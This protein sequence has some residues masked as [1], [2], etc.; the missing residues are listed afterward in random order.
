MGG[1][2]R[3][4]KWFI[5]LNVFLNTHRSTGTAQRLFKQDES[6]VS[7]YRQ[8]GLCGSE[9]FLMLAQARISRDRTERRVPV[10]LLQH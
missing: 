4:E 6:C 2:G 1:W 7:T 5:S 10:A 8:V 9:T 3:K